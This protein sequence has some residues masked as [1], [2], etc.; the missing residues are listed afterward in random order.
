[1]RWL[2][3]ALSLALAVAAAGAGQSG[4]A[5][6]P[7][8]VILF[9]TPSGHVSHLV[10]IRSDGTG[11][12][13]IATL[14]GHGFDGLGWS[15]DGKQVTFAA[16]TLGLFAK[17]ARKGG[18]LRRLASIFAIDPVWSPNGRWIAFISR[19]PTLAQEMVELVR[20]DGSGLHQ[21]G[22]V[23]QFYA[24]LSWAPDS[25]SLLLS[26]TPFGKVTPGGGSFCPHPAILDLS[27]M[28]RR[29][30]DPGCGFQPSSS[31]DGSQITLVGT[32]AT[33]SNVVMVERQDG[34]GLRQLTGGPADTDPV[35][36][37]SGA[38]IGLTHVDGGQSSVETVTA[39]G[40]KIRVVAISRR[41]AQA[42]VGW[43]PNGHLISFLRF[44]PVEDFSVGA[45]F[46][47]APDG[48]WPRKLVPQISLD[49]T[50]SWRPR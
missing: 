45:L 47:V 4:T 2:P 43:S 49:P 41:S 31:P 12:R 10:A 38:R 30:S 15:P 17:P 26:V 44:D 9:A 1:M 36:S 40:G 50:P 22:P 14:Y 23:E 37:P 35:W 33:G 19:S 27:G 25:D 11:R 21:L 46:V 29:L 39:S 28:L 42:M 48:Q 18:R 7:K 16:D 34:S 6:Q 20:P 3:L 13:A 8:P 5:S 32:L 24:D